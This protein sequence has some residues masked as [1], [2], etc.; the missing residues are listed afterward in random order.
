MSP[1]DPFL[2]SYPW[3][4]PEQRRAAVEEHLRPWLHHL[5]DWRA[6]LPAAPYGPW[7]AMDRAA[8]ALSEVA[9]ALT[10]E[11]L[12]RGEG[13]KAA[14]AVTDHPQAAAGP[15]IGRSHG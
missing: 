12:W 14:P 5:N 13:R 2:H 10:G 8:R 1:P 4:P 6:R 3:M 15:C 7:M 11:P 9:E